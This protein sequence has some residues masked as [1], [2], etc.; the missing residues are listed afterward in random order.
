MV[1][2]MESDRQHP[3]FGRLTETRA[4]DPLGTYAVWASKPAPPVSG[5]AWMQ[6]FPTRREK[7]SIGLETDL[8]WYAFD[9]TA[10]M[11][12]G[13]CDLAPVREA[14]RGEGVFPVSARVDNSGPY[15]MASIWLNTIR[16]SVCGRYHEV[17]VSFDA[18]RSV[19]DALACHASGR[20]ASWAILYNHFGPSA[21]DCQFLHSL[22]IDSPVSIAWGREMQAFPKHPLP[23]QTS[24]LDGA[25]ELSFDIGW[26]GGR[27]VLRGRIGKNFGLG[28][29]LRESLALLMTQRWAGMGSFLL[30]DSMAVPLRMPAKTAEQNGR[31]CDYLA[32]LWK[33]I[34]PM[35]VQVWPWGPQDELFLGDAREETGC[36]AHQAHLLLKQANFRPLTI[37]YAPRSAAFVETPD[38]PAGHPVKGLG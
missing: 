21:C 13:I 5:L 19:E 37:I 15:A 2:G 31:G 22:W 10:C 18:S 28:G 32:N 12:K 25:S 24:I 38:Q 20:W 7:L 23:T 16:D 1:M 34:H 9:F 35:A 11:I 14:L 26:P 36:E 33:G 17:V 6:S 29:L 4:G 27:T 8:N 3:E 30:G